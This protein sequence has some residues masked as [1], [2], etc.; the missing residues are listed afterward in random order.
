MSN[1]FI[2]V[3]EHCKHNPLDTLLLVLHACAGDL[4]GGPRPQTHKEIPFD[5]AKVR[6]H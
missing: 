3:I 2:N 1:A 4:I 5:W 6:A